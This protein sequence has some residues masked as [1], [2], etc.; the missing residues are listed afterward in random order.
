MP[1][2]IDDYRRIANNTL[3]KV[4]DLKQTNDR[5]PDILNANYIAEQLRLELE[6]CKVRLHLYFTFNFLF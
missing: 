2:L 4:F 1:D 6:E 3:N 5:C